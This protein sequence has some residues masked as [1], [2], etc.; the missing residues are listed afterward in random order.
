MAKM[1][2]R[3]CK[4]FTANQ[5]NYVCAKYKSAMGL[6]S[7]HFIREEVLRCLVLEHIKRALRYI[8]QFES[9]F[10]RLKYEQ[11]FEDRRRAL[12]KTKRDI[13]MANRRLDEL[14]TLFKHIYEDHVLGKLSDERFHIMSSDYEAEQRQLKESVLRMEADVAKGE[15]IT[16]DFQAFLT[17]VRKYT[18]VEELTPTILNE[19]IQRIDVH[20]PDKSSGKRIQQIDIFYNAVGVIDIPTPEEMEVLRA[21]HEAAMQ[22]KHKSA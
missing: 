7:A 19:F 3:T 6:C 22:Q 17:N 21:E 14:D 15:E 1:H 12:T 5:D 4:S 13:I 10:V 8:Q 18:D 16:A 2:F 20:A 9:C 11:S